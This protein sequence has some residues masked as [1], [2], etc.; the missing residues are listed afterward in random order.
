MIG[1]KKIK[2]DSGMKKNI[3]NEKNMKENKHEVSDANET[4]K[5]EEQIEN[6]V[7]SDSVENSTDEKDPV[8][9]VDNVG[10]KNS[11]ISEETKTDQQEKIKDEK[12]EKLELLQ[13]QYNDLNDKYLRLFSEFDNFRK[14]NMKE[15]IELTKTASSDIITS[16]LPVLDDLERAQNSAK[17]NTSIETMVEGLGLIHNKLKTTLRQKGLE[18]IPSIGEEFD[19]DYHEAITKTPAPNPKDKGK[20]IDQVEKGY[21]LNGKVLRFAKVVVAN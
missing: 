15:K 7:T 6:Q 16:I 2:T 13:K 18:E 4:N 12:E 21:T 1:K 9:D 17:D 10:D 20:V 5:A 14:R 8:E 3:Q 19:T 11:E